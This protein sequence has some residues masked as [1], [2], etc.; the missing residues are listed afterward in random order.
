MLKED[1]E[2]DGDDTR[3]FALPFCPITK[4]RIWCLVWIHGVLRLL[5]ECHRQLVVCVEFCERLDGFLNSASSAF[6]ASS[7]S[8]IISSVPAI[9]PSIV[10][11]FPWTSPFAP[12]RRSFSPPF[13]LIL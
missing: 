1:L 10:S 5:N 4:I 12:S 11:I 3:C 6:L 13:F 9:S 8:F 2:K 7:I